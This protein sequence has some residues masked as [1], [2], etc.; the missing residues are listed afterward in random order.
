MTYSSPNIQKQAE[1]HSAYKLAC[2]RHIESLCSIFEAP[3]AFVG[4][5]SN[6][7]VRYQPS[8]TTTGNYAF[9]VKTHT[10]EQLAD[11]SST[12]LNQPG[13]F[14]PANADKLLLMNNN[15]KPTDFD[16]WL[17]CPMSGLLEFYA[18]SP[19]SFRT[20]ALRRQTAAANKDNRQS[21]ILLLSHQEFTELGFVRKLYPFVWCACNGF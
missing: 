7:L 17:V 3:E 14:T 12:T 10:T 2:V 4:L 1:R 11:G 20:S 9:E 18:D 13:W 8:V 16:S 5:T 21:S 6:L 15:S 19:Q